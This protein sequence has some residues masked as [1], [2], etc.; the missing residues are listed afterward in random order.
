[1][2]K[3]MARCASIPSAMAR[4]ARIGP[5]WATATMSRP[6]WSAVSRVTTE[7]TRDMTSRKLSPSGARL[8]VPH[9]SEQNGAST[10][11]SIPGAYGGVPVEEETSFASV[12]I[13]S[14]KELRALGAE[15][16]VNA[17]GEDESDLLYAGKKL[18]AFGYKA[19]EIIYSGKTWDVRRID[20]DAANALMTTNEDRKLAG[21]VLFRGTQF[22]GPAA[23]TGGLEG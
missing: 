3:D 8:F 5:P 12:A 15:V 1:M 14:T 7:P 2:A 21:P 22:L 20:A 16:G 19:H 9:L 4:A 13:L 11:R 10:T 18:L 23:R 6:R 17:V